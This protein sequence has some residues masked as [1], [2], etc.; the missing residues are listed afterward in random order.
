[1]SCKKMV[2]K[3]GSTIIYNGFGKYLNQIIVTIPETVLGNGWRKF[4][5]CPGHNLKIVF[6]DKDERF[7]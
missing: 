1:M 4:V 2:L 3:C 5:P 6:I 7:T